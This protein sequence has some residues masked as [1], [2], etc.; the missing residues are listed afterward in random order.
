ME[1]TDTDW[2]ISSLLSENSKRFEQYSQR[3]ESILNLALEKF[4]KDY[5]NMTAAVGTIGFLGSFVILLLG[6]SPIVGTVTSIT[7]SILIIASMILRYKSSKS[8]VEYAGTLIELER[9]RSAFAQKSAILQHIW[10]YGLP[11][12]TPLAQVAVLLGNSNTEMFDKDGQPITWKKL[13]S[14]ENNTE[15]SDIEDL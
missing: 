5:T 6:K 1:M 14:P 12:G 9:E 3:V 11:E 13:P 4:K 2:R 15:N 8:Q 10:L 7:G